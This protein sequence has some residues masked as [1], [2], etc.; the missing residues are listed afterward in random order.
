MRKMQ[1]T[2][3]IREAEE[4]QGS[5]PDCSSA[6]SNAAIDRLR[7]VDMNNDLDLLH[8]LPETIRA[9]QQISS[10]KAPGLDAI[11]PEVY[12]HGGPRL[13][14]DLTT[15]FQEMW[16]Q[17]QVPQSISTNGRGPGNLVM[18]TEASRCSTSSG[19]SSPASFSIV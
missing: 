5:V 8:Y 17:G 9:V 18:I 4:I 12:K 16:R 19:R 1:D 10:S 7:Q 2:W 13:M 3:M 14:A 15:L 11:P 6:I